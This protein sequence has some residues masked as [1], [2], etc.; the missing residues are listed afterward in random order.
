MRVPIKV[1]LTAWYVTLLAGVLV[2]LA[3]FLLVRL[4]TDLTAAVDR[5]LDDRAAQISLS[6]EGTG[7]EGEFRDTTG[8]NLVLVPRSETVDQLLSPTGQVLRAAGDAAAA[9]HALIAPSDIRR[10]AAGGRVRGTVNVGTDRE[11]FRVLAVPIHGQH[12]ILVVAESME[13]VDRS[14]HRLLFLLLLAGPVVLAA[15]GAGG[16][17]LARKALR[18]VS[19]MTG[20]AD[21]IGLDRLDERVAVPNT[22]D[23]IAHL[24]H[25]LNAMLD[26]LEHG[27]AEKRRFLSD[28]SH[29]LRTPLAVMRSEIE[30]SL[31]SDRL[32]GEA[33]AVLESAE[34]E[35][36]RM[37]AIVENLLTLARIDEGALKLLRAPVALSDVAEHVAGRLRPLADAKRIR[38]NVSGNGAVVEGDRERLYQAVSN[39]VDNA[40]KY[41]EAGGEVRISVWQRGGEAG[42]TVADSGPG[43]PA[44]SLHRIFD[45]F[46]RADAAR[47]RMAGGTGLGLAIAREIVEAHGGRVWAESELRRGSAFSLALPKVSFTASERGLPP[48]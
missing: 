30:V 39:L 5:S 32:S 14:V 40:V 16:W 28:A 37:T 7:G 20:Q 1:R 15:A 35:I 48:G 47:S 21:A 4:R 19:T 44:E 26:R 33:R 6:F 22:S 27:V 46:V 12:R 29:E 3:A 38:L 43:I 17:W 41:S 42:L 9:R 18:P 45:R 31:R 34:E 23:E 2:A 25:T 11:P 24:G 13:Q 8:P 36:E 10:V